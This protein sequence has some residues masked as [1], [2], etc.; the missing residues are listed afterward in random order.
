MLL[1]LAAGTPVELIEVKQGLSEEVLGQ[2]LVGRALFAEQYPHLR[3]ERT[4]ALC[5][6]ADPRMVQVCRRADVNVHVEV[7][8]NAEKPGSPMTSRVA[9][10][11]KKTWLPAIE[12]WR[13][14]VGG[15]LFTRIPL[16]LTNANLVRIP[17]GPDLL[18]TYDTRERLLA[19]THGQAVTLV[20][21]RRKL[22]RGVVG[23]VVAHAAM[24]HDEYGIEVGHR[25]LFVGKADEAIVWSC[26]RFGIEVRV[27]P[28]AEAAMGEG[29]DEDDEEDQQDEDAGDHA[30]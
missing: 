9:C 16:G 15:L 26:E 23:R 10:L 21:V 25:V 4:V 29:E 12:N 13:T 11:F 3:V 2:C 22:S 6:V 17:D 1:D 5:K 8:P 14:E 7:I 18:A 27:V 24:L 30:D 20:E 28:S 19:A